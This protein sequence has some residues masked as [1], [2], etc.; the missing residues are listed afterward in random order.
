MHTDAEPDCYVVKMEKWEVLMMLCLAL[1]CSLIAFI[2]LGELV[3]I[4]VNGESFF[5][6]NERDKLHRDLYSYAGLIV[7]FSLSVW[8]LW[9]TCWYVFREEERNQQVVFFGDEIRV[10]SPRG[11][12]NYQW[13]E[14]EK[15]IHKIDCNRFILCFSTG[16]R[17]SLPVSFTIKRPYLTVDRISGGVFISKI[18]PPKLRESIAGDLLTKSHRK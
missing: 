1:M 3:M 4:S 2:T 12:I 11:V 14:L 5:G 7:L 18:H 13:N 8:V 17:V 15:V 10:I 16:D 6:V 9:K